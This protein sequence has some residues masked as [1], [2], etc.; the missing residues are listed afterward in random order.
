MIQLK[1]FGYFLTENSEQRLSVTVQIKFERGHV[2]QESLLQL[3][4]S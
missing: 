3:F 2:V 4:F 1:R